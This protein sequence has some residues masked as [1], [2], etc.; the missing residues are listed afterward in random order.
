MVD[1]KLS[2]EISRSTADNLQGISKHRTTPGTYSKQIIQ[3]VSL[4]GVGDGIHPL[5]S[6]GDGGLLLQSQF[7]PKANFD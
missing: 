7:G 4:P 1:T 6:A 3:L 2:I 5:D